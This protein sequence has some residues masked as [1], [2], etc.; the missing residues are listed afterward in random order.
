MRTIPVNVRIT[1]K[2]KCREGFYLLFNKERI[3]FK[4]KA[5]AV[6]A[7]DSLLSMQKFQIVTVREYAARTLKQN[8][9]NSANIKKL[10]PVLDSEVEN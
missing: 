10:P 5:A 7:L 8:K 2:R 9:K 4:N 6:G 1:R 3:H